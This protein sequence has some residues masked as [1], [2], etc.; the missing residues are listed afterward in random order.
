MSGER[1]HALAAGA[2]ETGVVSHS[3]K[4]RTVNEDQFVVRPDVGVWAVADGMGG[5]DD[6]ALASATVAAA[7]GTLGT[8]TSAPDLL[9]QLEDRVLMA[10]SE[11]RALIR[12]RGGRM[13]GSTIA[14]L[15]V[16]ER[17]YACVWSGDSRI[18]LVRDGAIAQVSRDHTEVE[19]LLQQGLI[20]SEEARH[21]PRRHIITRA[22]GVQDVPELDLDSG[23]LQH[24]DT[25]VLCSDGLTD[26][27]GDAEILAAVDGGDCQPACDALLG[28][29]L[30]R[31]ASDNVTVVIVRYHGGEP[32][33]TRW[34]PNQRR[35]RSEAP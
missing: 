3:G 23:D 8:A 18:Y 30:E 31:G 13:M 9:A 6:G 17:H 26:H 2:Y 12:A 22:I 35:Q 5:H 19:E 29:T 4:V 15:L 25:F 11:L 21:W 1:R 32:D 34:I 16:H 20:S 33:R 7:L 10:N 24:L 28:L 14:T 27:V